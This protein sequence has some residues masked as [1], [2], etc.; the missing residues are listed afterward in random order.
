MRGNRVS[1]STTI[2]K[3][4]RQE[5]IREALSGHRRWIEAKLQVPWSTTVAIQTALPISQVAVR[6]ILGYHLQTERGSK[7]SSALLD[8]IEAAEIPPYSQAAVMAGE[9]LRK[10]S[11]AD[12]IPSVCG[13]PLEWLDTPVCLRVRGL[14]ASLIA[15]QIPLAPAVDRFKEDIQNV[16]I[17]SLHL[18][19]DTM[20]LLKDLTLNK[21]GPQLVVLHGESTPVT[22]CGWE[23][24]VL[25]EAVTRLFQQDVRSFYQREDWFR[26]NRLPFHRGFLL[27]GIPGCGKTS[28]VR[29]LLCA[30]KMDAYTLRWFDHSIDDSDLEQLFKRAC[31]NKPSVVVMEDID[32]LFPSSGATAC[33]ISLQALLN[34][35]DG[36][37]TGDGVITIATAN[38]PAQLDRAILKRPGRFDRVIHFAPPDASLLL[39]YLLKLNPSLESV[40]LA[41]VVEESD[42]DSYAQLREAF[43]MAGQFAF[44]R[45]ADITVG[46]LLEGVRALRTTTARAARPSDRAGFHTLQE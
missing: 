3:P 16:V 41:Q 46:D 27:W 9:D 45:S 14:Q 1:S 25:D 13:Y 32:R 8:L 29:A 12:G 26:R 31:S 2:R 19:A 6:R 28:A 22:P 23:D 40:E 30:E 24:L 21:K 5:S 34:C 7:F 37:G 17:V 38:S 20:T 42:G 35:L 18:L 33:G 11:G 43:I 36:V 4:P 10:S 44:D 39:R 15:M